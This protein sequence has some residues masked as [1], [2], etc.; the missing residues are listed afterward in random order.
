[1]SAS[2]TISETSARMAPQV[3]RKAALPE[4]STTLAAIKPPSV[5]ATMYRTEDR[6][7][8]TLRAPSA[9]L[10]LTWSDSQPKS[11]PATRMAT[12]EAL[13]ARPVSPSVRWAYWVARTGKSPCIISALVATIRPNAAY[14]ISRAYSDQGVARV[15]SQA[16][17]ALSARS[18]AG[19][20]SAGDSVT[21]LITVT[22]AM[23]EVTK[24][25]RNTER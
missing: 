7:L 3:G 12:L 18:R 11:G 16:R 4:S 19:S 24:A 8:A 6:Q 15:T 14:G 17:V 10:R 2:A 21:N 22:S 1:M 25:I 9:S 23:H 13:T 5:G 20:G